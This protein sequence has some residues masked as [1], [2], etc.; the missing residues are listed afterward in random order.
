M[1]GD[2]NLKL[3]SI[4]ISN[5]FLKKACSEWERGE[6]N[7]CC[8]LSILLYSVE[9]FS[10]VKLKTIR[11]KSKT[12]RGRSLPNT[13]GC[14]QNDSHHLAYIEKLSLFREFCA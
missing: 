12:G 3:L 2:E 5:G 9:D 10:E 14:Q 6:G 4:K 1:S 13:P 7:C 8:I 11:L